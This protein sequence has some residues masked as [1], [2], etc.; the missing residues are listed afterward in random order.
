MHLLACRPVAATMRRAALMSAVGLALVLVGVIIAPLNAAADAVDPLVQ[1]RQG[2]NQVIAVFQDKTQTLGAR[3]ERLR[4]LAARFFD[5]NDM[6][7]SVLGYHWRGLSVQQRAAFVPLFTEFIQDAYLSKL[8]DYT[9]QKIRQE[10]QTARI[11]Y[12]RESFDGP[13]YAQVF[14]NVTLREQKD[15]V[16]VNYLMHRRDGAWRIYDLTIDAISVIANYRNQFDRVI[17]NQGYAELLAL[18]KEKQTQ[19]RQRMEHPSAAP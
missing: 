1:V 16:Q 18:M 5:F 9:V 6:A 4:A 2:V 14:T 13:D 7:K 19:L 8:E 17:N 11:D 15:P 3:R 12:L 10:A